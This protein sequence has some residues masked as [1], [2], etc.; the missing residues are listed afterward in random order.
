M[1]DKDGFLI[2]NACSGLL[3]DTVFGICD[4]GANI[5]NS[6]MVL[7]EGSYYCP[8]CDRKIK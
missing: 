4:C 5:H 7:K 1:F 6:C 3:H 2:C 8:L